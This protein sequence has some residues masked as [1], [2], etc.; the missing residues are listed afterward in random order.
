MTGQ[1]TGAPRQ[2]LMPGG[3]GPAG[4]VV[5]VVANVQ[6]ERDR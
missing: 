1:V 3:Q 5:G 4:V 2:P 6:D